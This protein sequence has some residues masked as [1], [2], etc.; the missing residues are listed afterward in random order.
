MNIVVHRDVDKIGYNALF[1]AI[2]R[3]IGLDI[4][5]F[6]YVYF[7]SEHFIDSS[8]YIP[9]DPL[10][11]PL[12]GNEIES[13]ISDLESRRLAAQ[14]AGSTAPEKHQFGNLGLTLDKPNQSILAPTNNNGQKLLHPLLSRL[15][16]AEKN[17]FN[18]KPDGY[19]RVS[20][21]SVVKLI[22]ILKQRVPN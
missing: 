21:T 19:P 6:R 5:H 12:T 1:E 20:K 10:S 2:K 8:N 18:M 16:R 13:L 14:N 7:L 15:Y 22:H 3:K 17:L 4:V 11:I 9:S